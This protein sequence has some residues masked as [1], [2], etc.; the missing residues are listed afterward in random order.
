MSANDANPKTPMVGQPVQRLVWTPELVSR[1]WA[2]VAQTRLTEYDF[3]KQGGKS[4]IIAVEHHLPKSGKILDFGAGNGELVELLLERGYFAAAY[5]PSTE[6]IGEWTTRLRDRKGFLGVVGSHS[7]EK[8]DVI[9]MTEVIEHILEDEF[10]RTL[11]RVQALLKKRG[12][13]IVTTPNNEDLELDM[14]YCPVSNLLYHRW[15]HVR[16]FTTESLTSCLRQYEID[17]I[18]VHRVNFQA[19][20][21]VPFDRNWAGHR[22]VPEMPEYLVAMRKDISTCVG[23]EARLLYIG[24]KIS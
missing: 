10:D 22:F 14:A 17:P 23:N 1:F 16:S 13:L 19:D 2:G 9:L 7:D 3:A 8:F 6:R 12:I 20:Y 11:R 15:Q 5:E 21:Y 18:A 24:Q 4:V